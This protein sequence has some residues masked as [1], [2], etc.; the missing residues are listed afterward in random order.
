MR[1]A[2]GRYLGQPP[3]TITI[4]RTCSGCGRLHGKPRLAPRLGPIEL[5]VSHGGDRVVVAVTWD[6]PVGVDVEPIS[7]DLPVDKLLPQVLTPREAEAL[8]GLSGMGRVT[9]FL[10][11]WTRKEAVVK[12]LGEGLTMPMAGFQVTPPRE[13]PRITAWPTAAR[14]REPMSL[15]DLHPGGHHVAS[16]AVHGDCWQVVEQDG[17]ALLD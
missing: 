6:T 14:G 16:L 5:S 2:L 10:T 4:L 7:A 3:S 13:P 15:H 17:S 12:A 1:G 11:Y 9:G 8:N